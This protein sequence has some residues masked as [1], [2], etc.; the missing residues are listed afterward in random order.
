MSICLVRY[1]E[2]AK[3]GLAEHGITAQAL[4]VAA[5]PNLKRFRL[6]VDMGEIDG[7]TRE[8]APGEDPLL[9]YA[10]LLIDKL[11]DW[12][13]VTEAHGITTSGMLEEAICFI[14]GL[15]HVDTEVAS[16]FMSRKMS[17]E[18]LTQI[19]IEHFSQRVCEVAIYSRPDAFEDMP[20]QVKSRELCLKAFKVLVSNALYIPDELMDIEM[21]RAL[22]A[23]D[24]WAI[25]MIP[26]ELR[27]PEFVQRACGNC[28]ST[29]PFISDHQLTPALLEKKRRVIQD[30]INR[31]N[32]KAEAEA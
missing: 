10:E 4:A 31:A 23:I 13:P 17:K 29:L 15:G 12:P 20:D 26:E 30:E 8:A 19:P 9:P 7:E 11:A 25:T 3:N 27:I 2:L 32:K 28:P 21:A 18:V 6:E 5:A 14:A 1:Q 22:I 24:P 16:L